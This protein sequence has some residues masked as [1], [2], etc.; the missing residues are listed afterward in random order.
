MKQKIFTLIMMFALV[1]VAGSAFAQGNT[2]PF[3][4]T[5][6]TYHITPITVASDGTLVVNYNGSGATVSTLRTGATAGDGELL[7]K[8]FKTT[9]N[10]IYFDITYGTDPVAAD[11]TITVTVRDNAGNGCSNNITLAIDVILPTF[12]LDLGDNATAACQTLGTPP[13]NGSQDAASLGYTPVTFVVT[14]SAGGATGYTYNFILTMTS[15]PIITETDVTYRA[16]A[17]AGELTQ[18]G[19]V[20][21]LTNV[22]AGATTITVYVATTEG[23]PATLIGTLSET[24]STTPSMSYN[25]NTIYGT[26][27]NGARDVPFSPMPT[28]GSF[29]GL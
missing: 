3:V 7:S 26:I 11:G 14:P 24:A 19:Q 17:S 16:I 21:T 8:V 20:L 10:Q 18:S 2:T 5:T 15:N 22:P 29:V 25:S 12:T 4:G 28:I 6:K 1:I 13:T 27:T 23:S 9:M